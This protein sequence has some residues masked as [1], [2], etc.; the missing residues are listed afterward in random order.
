MM[1]ALSAVVIAWV[2]HRTRPDPA[3]ARNRTFAYPN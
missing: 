2:V 1:R 3:T